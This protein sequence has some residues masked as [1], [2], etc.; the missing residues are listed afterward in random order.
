MFPV[1]LLLEKISA[2]P[3]KLESVVNIARANTQGG[4]PPGKTCQLGQVAN[5]TYSAAYFFLV[6]V[7]KEKCARK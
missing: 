1:L 3:G 7:E 6:P 5:V 2:T 4:M